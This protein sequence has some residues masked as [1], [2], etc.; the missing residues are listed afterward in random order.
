MIGR[1][2]SKRNEVIKDIQIWHFLCHGKKESKQNLNNA[3]MKPC[4]S[5]GGAHVQTIHMYKQYFQS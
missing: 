5:V 3:L 4:M 1:K 2:H